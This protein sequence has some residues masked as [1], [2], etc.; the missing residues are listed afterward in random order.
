MTIFGA[1][2]TLV[3]NGTFSQPAVTG[4][5][6]RRI[7]DL[8][9]RF[10]NK[11]VVFLEYYVCYLTLPCLMWFTRERGC[12]KIQHSLSVKY[13]SQE[14]NLLCFM[15]Y[16]PWFLVLIAFCLSFILNSSFLLVIFF[17]FYNK[18][19]ITTPAISQHEK[20]KFK[21]YFWYIHLNPTFKV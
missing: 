14:K 13:M 8:M 2:Q 12:R 20:P 10:L 21:W 9:A 4:R 19:V 17:V 3:T 6:K 18:D 1:S 16:L 7:Y 5:I 15:K 11:I